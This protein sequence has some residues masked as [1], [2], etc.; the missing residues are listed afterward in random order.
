MKKTVTF[1][2]VLLFVLLVTACG[3]SRISRNSPVEWGQITSFS[4]HWG[5]FHGGHQSF[6]IAE[7]DGLYLFNAHGEMGVQIF[8]QEN[9]PISAYQLGALRSLLENYNVG[10]WNGFS[11][12]WC[13][14]CTGDFSLGLAI[15]MDTGGEIR[16]NVGCDKPP[17]FS[18]GFSQ[19]S[20][21]L[22]GLAVEYQGAPEWG[23]LRRFSFTISNASIGLH[24]RTYS[25]TANWDGTVYFSGGGYRDQV[26]PSVLRDLH[27]LIVDYGIITWWDGHRRDTEWQAGYHRVSVDIAFDNDT[28]FQAWGHVPICPDGTIRPRPRPRRDISRP[29]CDATNALLDFFEA[30]EVQMA[31]ERETKVVLTIAEWALD[32]LDAW[33]E[34]YDDATITVQTVELHDEIEL[35]SIG[36]EGTIIIQEIRDDR[37]VVQIISDGITNIHLSRARLGTRSVT[38]FFGREA[39]YLFTVTEGPVTVWRLGFDRE[40]VD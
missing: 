35:Y 32:S 3:N 36:M 14:D 8:V 25:V 11:S 15:V 31:E 26:D 12:G 19:L 34:N 24:D 7:A 30:L 9:T 1:A 22:H 28:G 4:M 27:Q 5:D 29:Q 16:V 23:S 10:N 21:F 20:N 39:V 33:D 6:R 13:G 37:I 17:Y 40:Y 2:C 38:R 18:E